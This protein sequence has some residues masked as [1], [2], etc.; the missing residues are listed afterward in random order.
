MNRKNISPLWVAFGVSFILNLFFVAVI[1]GHMWRAHIVG[2]Q[3]RS[4]LAAALVRAESGLSPK[5]AAAFDA[6]IR[7]DAP[8]YMEAARHL[9]T[10]RIAVRDQV[11]AEK[12]DPEKTR[13]ALARWQAAWNSFLGDFD[14]TLV[15]AL[16]QVSPEGRRK[17]A[18]QRRAEPL[19]P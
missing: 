10:T 4:P 19:A 5:D 17:L 18:F 3:A 16:A 1:G 9:R 13:E 14:D 7:R 12:F 15:N 11:T 8:H 2:I 6:V